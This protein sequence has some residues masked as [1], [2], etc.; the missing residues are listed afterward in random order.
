M[1]AWQEEH[2]PDRDAWRVQLRMDR[3]LHQQKTEFQDLVLFENAQFGRVLALDGIVQTTERDEFIYHEMLVHVPVLAHG[4][5]KRA[6][7]VGGGDGGA[8]EELLKH[9]SV[10]QVT[11]VEID[12]GVVDFAREH[13][14]PICGEAFDDPR[15]ALEIADGLAW[16][17][18]TDQRFD[19]IVV[20][21]TDPVEGPGQVLFS[22]TFYRAC[23]ARLTDGGVLVTQNA[24]PFFSPEFLS[25]PIGALQAAFGHVA[26][27]RAAVPS[28]YG[29]D[30]VYAL[31]A[32][33]VNPL[34]VAEDVL[35]DRL[36]ASGLTTRHYT[37]AVHRGAFALPPWMAELVS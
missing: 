37:P 23:A 27:Y 1:T 36:A 31:A 11:M 14:R 20:D 15:F 22:E 8:L 17:Q 13:L 3:V 2:D 7:I 34:T 32:D 29:G 25:K 24:V 28:F 30:M 18:A 16:V 6:L 21:S 26:A 4:A 35:T 5:V 19:L 10:E 33:R 9:R 12:R